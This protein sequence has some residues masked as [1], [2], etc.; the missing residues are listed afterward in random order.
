VQKH[1]GAIAFDTEPGAGTT[2]I[3][4]LPIAGSNGTGRSL[5]L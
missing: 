5:S 4:R 1:G 2:F 3:V